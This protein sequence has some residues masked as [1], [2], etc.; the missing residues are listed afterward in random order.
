MR[1]DFVSK[2]KSRAVF[3]LYSIS[4][5][6]GKSACMRFILWQGNG[7]NFLYLSFSS[8]GWPCLLAYIYFFLL[9]SLNKFLPS[10]IKEGRKILSLSLLVF[11]LNE[12][13]D[14]QSEQKLWSNGILYCKAKRKEIYFRVVGRI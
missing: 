5:L 12:Q 14:G 13:S 8:C 3:Y 4:M 9:P 11:F 7:H 2:F 6:F 1:K 10:Y